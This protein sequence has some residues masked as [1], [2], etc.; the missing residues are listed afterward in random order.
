LAGN[1]QRV[2]LDAAARGR[3]VVVVPELVVREVVNK[4]REKTIG[5]VIKLRDGVGRLRKYGVAVILPDANQLEAEA[6]KVE[7]ALRAKLKMPGVLN[8][9]FPLVGHEPLVQRALDRRL[10]FTRDGKDGYRDAVLWETVIELAA[11]CEVILVSKDVPAFA[12]SDKTTLAHA[13]ASEVRERLGDTASVEL[14]Q[15]L[16]A[17]ADR[18]VAQDEKALH[19]VRELVREKSFGAVLEEALEDEIR[20]VTLG[21]RHF[22]EL[23]VSTRSMWGWISDL[24][25]LGAIVVTN[26]YTVSAGQTLAELDAAASVGV[27]FTVTPEEA[28]KF[29]YRDDIWPGR[30]EWE[31][32]DPYDKEVILQTEGYGRLRVNVALAMPAGR[33][34]RLEVIGW[35]FLND[36]EEHEQADFV[37]DAEDEDGDE[38]GSASTSTSA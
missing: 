4:W 31:D 25:E 27:A 30:G 7:A 34:D 15:D 20:T 18:L 36:D 16:Q 11:D 22:Q 5:E 24:N 6:I 17:V 32:I 23:K 13:L 21:P 38:N 19:A 8:P 2:V 35:R 29:Q 37:E 12:G 1:P 14:V 33:I 28:R 3:L 10:P 26:A 9:G